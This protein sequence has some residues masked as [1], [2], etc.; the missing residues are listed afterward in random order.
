MLDDTAYFLPCRTREQ[1]EILADLLASRPAEE[2][3]RT[4][5]FWDA[6]R[7][8]TSELLNR[9]DLT[10]LARE[11]ELEPELVRLFGAQTSSPSSRDAKQRLHPAD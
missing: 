6:K 4:Y 3:L 5:V 10:A 7:P 8:I 9:L 2:F 1:A 11:L